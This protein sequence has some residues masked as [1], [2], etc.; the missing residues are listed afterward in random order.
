M[1]FPIPEWGMVGR[2]YTESRHFRMMFT[3]FF[4]TIFSLQK[5][6]DIS[7]S[8]ISYAFY[9]EYINTFVTITQPFLKN[10]DA[11]LKKFVK[12]MQFL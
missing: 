4:Y 5:I 8:D 10:N 11:I 6:K 3:P 2:I 9:D 12:I 1:P 7:S